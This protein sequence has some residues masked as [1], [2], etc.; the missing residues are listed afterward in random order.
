LTATANGFESTRSQPLAVSVSSVAM[1][2][3]G[4]ATLNPP[5]D[6]GAAASAAV[7]FDAASRECYG[8][9]F[10]GTVNGGV[11]A[12]AAAGD[13]VLIVEGD[14]HIRIA[15]HGVLLHE[16]ALTLEAGTRIT[17]LAISR[18]F[19]LS[20]LLFVAWTEPSLAGGETLNITRYRELGG[21]LG[22]AA[23][24]VTGLPLTPGRAAP[25][26]LDDQ[27]LIYVAL[28]EASATAGAAGTTAW[29]NSILRFDADGR[30]PSANP[31]SSPVIAHGY[32]HPTSLVW[33]SAGG[34]LW[35]SGSDPRWPSPL[36]T[37]RIDFDHPEWP[38]VPSPVDVNRA[39]LAETPP[40]LAAP[41][42][43]SPADLQ[44]I[45]LLQGDGVARRATRTPG[46]GAVRFEAARL[47]R[48]G[49]VVALSKGLG[50]DLLLAAKSSETSEIWRLTPQSSTP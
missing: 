11:T 9:R 10:L 16:P 27:G 38:W 29:N 23:T 34:E 4:A 5:S 42:G 43:S 49:P 12:L 31:T 47:D 14:S 28:P 19:D 26:A 33:Q 24:I 45:W 1:L 21:T 15:A 20:R 2:G 46:H 50:R 8:A 30:V 32:A 13:L 22:E 39:G 40:L 36:S 41:A 35:L 44:Q 6:P 18:D 37:L 48:L 7:C 17:G 25:I 3:D